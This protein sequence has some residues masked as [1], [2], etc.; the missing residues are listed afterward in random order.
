MK[1]N[2]VHFFM[3]RFFLVSLFCFD[4][5]LHATTPLTSAYGELL[6]VE[7]VGKIQLQFPYNINQDY[8][9]ALTGT[10]TTG[11]GTV[12][13][14]SPFAVLST[15]AA[16]NSTAL[17]ISKDRLHYQPGRGSEALFTAK[18]TIGAVGSTQL[19]GLGNLSSNTT[20]TF[21][22]IQDGFFFGWSTNA[23]TGL[24]E[25]GILWYYNGTFPTSY[26]SGTPGGF[27]PQSTWNVDRF[28]STTV[29][30]T[31]PSGVLLDTTKGNVYKIQ[32]QWLGFGIINFFI[33]NPS[34]GVLTVVHRIQFANSSTTTSL[35]NPTMQLMAAVSNTTNASNIALSFPSLS[36]ISEGLINPTH[37]SRFSV[38]SGVAATAIPLP[39]GTFN[40]ILT[41]HNKPIFQGLT[42]QVEIYP[43]FISMLMTT[44]T[45]VV[46]S[47]ILNPTFGAALA[48]ADVSTNT[49]ITEYSATVTTITAGTGTVLL[50]FYLGT[51]ISTQMEDLNDYNLKLEPNDVLCLAASRIN[52]AG[53]VLA[54]ISWRERF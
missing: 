52:G 13:H 17:L 25:F 16:I 4:C 24:A 14:S 26:T 23:T 41:I 28:N 36:G 48:Y 20:L 35:K 51:I 31:N 22:N 5:T 6:V 40:S 33:E 19:I 1:N 46:I 47:L 34:T 44:A 53:Q 30:S 9:N 45:D 18:F 49:S 43:E 11:S 29:S 2:T 54:A 37:D 7:P 32:Y 38:R 42:N 12:T 50:S 27:I 21:A 3:K 10:T 39:V 8:V 15:T